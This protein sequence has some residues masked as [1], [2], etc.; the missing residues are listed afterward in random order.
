MGSFHHRIFF[1]YTFIDK[2]IGIT[3]SNS[4]VC[5]ARQMSSRKQIKVRMDLECMTQN[6]FRV[7]GSL[8]HKHSHTFNVES[9]FNLPLMPATLLSVDTYVTRSHTMALST[10]NST[11][12]FSH[13]FC[14]NNNHHQQANEFKWASASKPKPFAQRIC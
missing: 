1:F 9:I 12:Y 13:P 7:S 8:S 5:Y 4:K 2:Q 11:L 6:Q 10:Q 14:T 3:Y